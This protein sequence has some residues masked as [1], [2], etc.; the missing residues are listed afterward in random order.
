MQFDVLQELVSHKF[1]IF[2]R[3]NDE[4]ITLLNRLTDGEKDQFHRLETGIGEES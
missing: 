4:L 3:Q 2:Y 1:L